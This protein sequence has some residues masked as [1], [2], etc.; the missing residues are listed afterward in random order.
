MCDTLRKI[1]YTKR[2][3]ILGDFNIDMMKTSTPLREDLLE[4]CDLYGLRMSEIGVTRA[5]WVAGNLQESCLDYILS[6]DDRF[7]LEKEMNVQSDHYVLKLSCFGYSKVI[8]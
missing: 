5:R 8:R 7:K 2:V 1:D 3:Y 4:W 6:N